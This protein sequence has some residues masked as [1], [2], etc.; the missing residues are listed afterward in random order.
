[1]RNKRGT[2]YNRSR[3]GDEMS[4][5]EMSECLTLKC[6]VIKC[7]Q[8]NAVDYSSDVFLK[9]Y[10]GTTIIMSKKH[11]GDR[12]GPTPAADLVTQRQLRSFW[13]CR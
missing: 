1:M 4:R 12:T 6:R 11:I 10:V 9:S 8:T 5:D 13:S 2:V 3:V 7:H